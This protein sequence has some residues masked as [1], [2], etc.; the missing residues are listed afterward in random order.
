VR[1]RQATWSRRW[2][3]GLS[4]LIVLLLLLVA[5]AGV[6]RR[7]DGPVVVNH[8]T[9]LGAAAAATQPAAT[10]R[11]DFRLLVKRS[12]SWM[13]GQVLDAGSTAVPRM[14][15]PAGCWAAAGSATA[16]NR[17]ASGKVNQGRAPPFAV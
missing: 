10:P 6:G 4:A 16:A 8:E 11:G 12:G 3:G 1:V 5:G 13:P 14:A 7:A 15:P 9:A 2:A 17:A